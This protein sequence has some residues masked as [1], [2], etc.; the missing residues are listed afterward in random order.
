MVDRT[1]IR[2][3]VLVVGSLLL[4]NGNLAAQPVLPGTGFKIDLVGDNFED[5][6]WSYILNDP[7]SSRNIDKKERGP[8]A[9]SKNGR[10]LEGPHR[11][12]PDIMKRIATPDGGLANSFGSLLMQTRNSG[13]PNK[14][15]G[16]PQQDDV[17]VKIRRRLGR[18]VP[19]SWNPNCVVRVFVPPFEQWENRTGA[20]FGFRTDC[21]GKKQGEKEL[22]QYWPGIFI[23]LRSET[24][25]RFGRDSAYMTIRADQRGRDIRGPEVTPGWWTLGMSVSA[26]GRCH[27]YARKGVEDL[28][29]EDRLASYYS[30]GYRCEKFDLF[31]FNVVSF[32]N[33]RVWSTP[34]VVDDPTFYCTQQL[35][36]NKKHRG[37][38][39]RR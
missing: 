22:E 36:A 35:A 10:W 20:S 2:G 33:G 32:D 13:I 5:S 16:K 29:P 8:L 39:T 19:P 3:L 6:K 24:D 26:D 27:F 25:R 30:Y 14:P 21:W 4:A 9:Q 23:N 17:M 38:L 18:S 11:G 31:F 15:T 1:I 28:R 12:T 7:K 37:R 34:W